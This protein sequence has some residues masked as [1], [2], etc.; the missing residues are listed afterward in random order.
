VVGLLGRGI[1]PTQGIYLNKTIQHRK[2][3]THIH[4][5]SGIRTH[6]PSV[7]SVEDSTCLRPRGHWDR[8]F[9]IIIIVVVVVVVVVVVFRIAEDFIIVKLHIHRA[10][11]L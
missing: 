5:S 10:T 1:N 6:D 8:H 4:V 3:Q 2:T 7:R 11:K 9:I